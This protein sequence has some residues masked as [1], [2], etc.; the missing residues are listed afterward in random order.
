MIKIIKLNLWDGADKRYA[1]KLGKGGEAAGL[2]WTRK[3]RMI[4]W[5]V[6]SASIWLCRSRNC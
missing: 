1:I 5:R 6:K 2:I 4:V 3:M